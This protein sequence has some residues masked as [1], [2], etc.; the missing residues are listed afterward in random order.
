MVLGDGC[1]AGLPPLDGPGRD[2]EPAGDLPRREPLAP[3]TLEDPR[4][5]CRYS[6]TGSPGR[7]ARPRPRRRHGSNTT[8]GVGW[9]PAGIQVGAQPPELLRQGHPPG[10]DLRARAA[11]VQPRR[12]TMRGHDLPARASTVGASTGAPHVTHAPATTDW[13]CATPLVRA[14]T[15]S[16]LPAR[17]TT[18]TV[19]RHLVLGVAETLARA[20]A[21][22]ARA[23]ST[24]RCGCPCSRR[25]RV[26]PDESL[27]TP[28]LVAGSAAHQCGPAPFL[29]GQREQRRGLSTVDGPSRPGRPAHGTIMSRPAA[30]RGREP[31]L[32]RPTPRAARSPPTWPVRTSCPGASVPGQ[33]PGPSLQRKPLHCR[34]PRC[35]ATITSRLCG[36]AASHDR[37]QQNPPG[38]STGEA[39]TS[40]RSAGGSPSTSR[41]V[42]RHRPSHPAGS[43]SPPTPAPQTAVEPGRGQPGPG[44]RRVPTG[45]GPGPARP[46]HGPGTPR[47]RGP[48]ATAARDTQHL[49]GLG[50]GSLRRA[51]PTGSGTSASHRR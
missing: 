3:Q 12:A 6:G 27:A 2:A 41:S 29:R 33:S 20:R 38:R 47:P 23:W 11:D 48:P 17:H 8:P 16:Q 5:S 9:W 24:P 46:R 36:G 39:L 51:T 45:A 28:D 25:G 50:P 1:E 31:P 42:R 40:P 21:R 43:P 34:I 15:L 19:P 18:D 13:A 7:R 49:G 26:R 37:L 22:A 30:G 35:P 4:R 44:R 14:I 32:D 10:E